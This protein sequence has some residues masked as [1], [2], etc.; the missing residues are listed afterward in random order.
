MHIADV[1]HGNLGANGIVAGSMTIAVG[2]ARTQMHRDTGKVVVCFFGDG[3][4]NE[5]A[6]HEAL[7]L[8]GVWKAPVVFV[9][10]N[11][12]YGMSMPVSDAT[13]GGSIAG[14]AGAYGMPGVQ[15]DGN[16][17]VEVHRTVAEAAQRART[18]GGP[19]L[20][21]AQT[22]RHRGHSK[23]DRNLYR[24]DEEI[25]RWRSQ[26]D[27]I[28]GFIAWATAKDLLDDEAAEAA[29]TAARERVRTAV[30]DAHAGAEPDV[31]SL[32]GA[33]YA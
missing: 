5:G 27:P 24:T 12:Q 22:Y 19:T 4:A 10:E 25:Q 6:F 1:A 16:D 14:R 21:E 23:S 3:A 29:R 13:A 2:A 26:H 11:N 28:A 32:E 15:V 20:I 31:A 9:C 18:G 33:A 8:A 7:N 17:L 30:R